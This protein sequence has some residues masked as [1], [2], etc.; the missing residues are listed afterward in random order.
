MRFP[1]E[2]NDFPPDAF[3]KRQAA[4]ISPMGTLVVS[5]NTLRV[6]K[7][8]SLAQKMAEQALLLKTSKQYRVPAVQS[9]DVLTGFASVLAVTKAQE[10][11]DATIEK[12]QQLS[13]HFL[14]KSIKANERETQYVT[15]GAI[16]TYDQKSQKVTFVGD[17]K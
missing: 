10:L 15:L 11:R 14:L 17:K 2:N 1:L 5:P 9:D 7:Y 16:S 13:D 3:R 8:L 4:F 12:L 6:N